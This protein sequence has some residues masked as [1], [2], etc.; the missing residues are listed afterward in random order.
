MR[1]DDRQREVLYDIHNERQE[2]KGNYLPW[3][4]LIIL[5]IV[6]LKASIS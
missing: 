4:L 6:L 1:V 5:I 2:K 3:I